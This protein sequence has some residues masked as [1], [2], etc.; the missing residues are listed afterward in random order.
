MVDGT[1]MFGTGI[2]NSGF[3]SGVNNLQAA[4]NIALG[5]IAADMVNQVLGGSTDSA[6]GYCRWFWL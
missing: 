6:A 1:L 2:D 5:N 3:T 4:A